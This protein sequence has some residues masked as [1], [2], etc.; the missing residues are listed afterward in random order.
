MRKLEGKRIALLGSRKVAEVSKIVENFGGTPFSRPAQGTVFLDE[1]KLENYITRIVNGKYDW[2]IIT[3]GIGLETLYHC[4]EKMEMKE[5]FISALQNMKIAARGYKAVNM[6]KKLGCTP[7]VRDDDGSTAGLIRGL[8]AFTLNQSKVA[9]QLHGNPIPALVQW[10]QSQNA[11]FEEILPYIHISPDKQVMEKLLEEILNGKVDAA[12]FTSTPQVRN[13]FHHAE[14]NSIVNELQ[15]A[16]SQ[17]T[18]ALAIGKI[19]AEALYTKGLNR[20]IF[21]QKERIG[22]AIVELSNYYQQLAKI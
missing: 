14:Q 7:L 5:K 13:L 17:Q 6:L 18:I 3:T 8:S 10:L 1:L 4:A 21:P 11:T 9:I 15:H 20:V 22:S 16:F 19:T 12:I 2:I